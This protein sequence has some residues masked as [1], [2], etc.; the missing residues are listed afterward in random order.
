MS[1][2]S[3]GE[4]KE[5]APGWERIS[6][7][8]FLSEVERCAKNLQMQQLHPM[9]AEQLPYEFDA[10]RITTASGSYEIKNPAYMLRTPTVVVL[11]ER[12]F[13]RRGARDLAKVGGS[14]EKSIEIGTESFQDPNLVIEVRRRQERRTSW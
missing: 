7:R 11:G 14:I 13:S 12:G 4:V 2:T 3:R 5:G 1:E 10:I 9:D 6:G 8:S